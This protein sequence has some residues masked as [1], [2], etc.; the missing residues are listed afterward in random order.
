MVQPTRATAADWREAGG[1]VRRAMRRRRA[2]P[3]PAPPARLTRRP[4]FM[5][6][7]LPPAF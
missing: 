3:P 2:A 1:K 7:P 4:S 6:I 5:Q